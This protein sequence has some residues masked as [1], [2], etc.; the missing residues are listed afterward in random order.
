MGT[1]ICPWCHKEIE[2]YD[3]SGTYCEHCGEY[4]QG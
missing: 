3:E 1:I 4:T 2:D